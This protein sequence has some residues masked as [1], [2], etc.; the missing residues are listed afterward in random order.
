MISNDSTVGKVNQ[1]KISPLR[2]RMLSDMQV[3]GYN[4]A[5]ETA[6]VRAISVNAAK[7]EFN[8]APIS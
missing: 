6:Y 5:T 4:P 2:A 8:G 1:Q 7:S 3:R